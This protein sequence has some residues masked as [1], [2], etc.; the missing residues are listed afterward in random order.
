VKRVGVTGSDGFMGK[1]LLRFFRSQGSPFKIVDFQVEWFDQPEKMKEFVSDCD[2]IVHLAGVNRHEDEK[3]IFNRNVELTEI[4]IS[5]VDSVN[6]TP[7]FIFSSSTQEYLNNNY[8]TAKKEARLKLSSWASGNR[9]PFTGLIIPNVYGPFGQPFYNSF[10]A[11]F[12]HLLAKRGEPEIQVDRSVGLIYVF[13]IAK[14]IYQ[15]INSPEDNPELLLPITGEAAVS[16]VLNKLKHFSELY[17]KE[18]RIP[19]LN[20]YFDVTLFNTFRSYLVPGFYPFSLMKR[21]DDRGFLTEIIKENTGGQVFYS[22]TKPGIT[23]GNHYHTN[24]IERF[25]VLQGEGLIRMRRIEE[26]EIFEFRVSGDAPVIIDMPVWYTH[27]ITNVGSS[28]MLTLFWSN[29][30]FDPENPDTY[31]EAV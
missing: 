2:V 17:Q 3:Y 1:N 20:N 8:G 5:A 4:L 21:T 31:F 23:R 16:E 18:A 22:S 24:K 30:I 19:E 29:E 6:A 11:T 10:I 9:V 27:N 25:C 28:E 26:N 13:E 12:C 15:L 7:Y 14:K